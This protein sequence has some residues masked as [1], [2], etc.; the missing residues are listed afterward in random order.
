LPIIGIP[1]D[2]GEGKSNL[3][4]SF[5]WEDFING[6][7]II[8]DTN[9][10]FEEK[11]KEL[12][13]DTTAT[14]E[15]FNPYVLRSRDRWAEY[16]GKSL[17][18]DE[19]DTVV[20]SRRSQSKENISLSYM[21]FWHRKGYSKK[22]AQ[23]LTIYYTTHQLNIFRDDSIRA[24]EVRIDEFTNFFFLPTAYREH[25]LWIWELPEFIDVEMVKRDNRG[26]LVRVDEFRIDKEVIKFIGTL[27]DTSEIAQNP[28]LEAW[29][30]TETT[31]H[32]KKKVFDTVG[33]NDFPKDSD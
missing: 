8:T 7:D 13:I 18:I 22:L 27:Y 24:V 10:F 15:W 3:A 20:D 26:R 23:P 28:Y 12:Q 16:A 32:K 17:F 9:L 33:K 1:A 14:V 21:A 2:V 4:V 31:S 5:L 25:P 30:E 19:I 11:A 29:T 6:V